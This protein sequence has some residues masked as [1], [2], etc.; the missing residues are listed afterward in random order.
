MSHLSSVLDAYRSAWQ[1]RVFAV[2]LYLG[3]RLLALALVAPAAA[4]VIRLA[5][6]SSDQSALTD[7][8]I[9]WF[10]LSPWGFAVTL[11]AL[12]VLL[13]AEV[14]GFAVLAAALRSGKTGS[15]AAGRAGLGLVLWRMRGLLGFAARLILRVLVIAAPFLALAGLVAWWRL[16]AHDINYYLTVKPPEFVVAVALIAA[17]LALMAVVLIRRLSS[18]ALALHLVLFEAVHPAAAFTASTARMQGRRGA[19]Q[20]DIVFWLLMRLALAGI[21]ALVA[22]GLLALVPLSAETNLKL[23]L[24]VT[25]LI[26]ALWS[27]AGLALAALALT[28]LAVLLDGYLGRLPD[29]AA[30]PTTPPGQSWLPAGVAV[31]VAVLALGIWTGDR[32]LAAA[33]AQDHAEV[34]GHRGA[35]AAAPENTM[36][37]VH[38][39]LDDGADWVEIDVQET[40]DGIVVV[41]HDS[42]F[43]KLAGVPTKI[44]DARMSDLDEIDVGS[45]FAPQFA[46][47]RVPTL[48]DVLAAARGRAKVIIELKYYGHD[49]DLENRVVEIVEEMDMAEDVAVMSLKYPAVQKMRQ[50]RPDWRTGVL[51]AT[52][53]GDLTGLEGD[54]IAVSAGRVTP[55][56]LRSAETAGKDVYAWT[57]NDPLEMSRLLS[58]GIDGLITDEPAMANK[59]LAFRAELSPTGRLLLW[60][61]VELGLDFDMDKTVNEDP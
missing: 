59:V 10:I 24:G 51:A 47:E 8:D 14:L 56:L 55:A 22:S 48:S 35:A 41:I 11:I 38:R 17:I 61:A 23:A 52:A 26:I 45:W 27:L 6:A 50:L 4:L 29:R 40:A 12:S 18:W 28:A 1:N 13:V 39:A 32:L 44:W 46:E 36:A 31:A 60:L 21:I 25:V 30:V 43:M 58:M 2:P 54:F 7:Q 3:L 16:T 37:S 42:D 19:I 20:R 49:E 53:V 34:I 9:A 33:D 57:V 15:L 5:V